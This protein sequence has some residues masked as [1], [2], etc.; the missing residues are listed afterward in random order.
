MDKAAWPPYTTA[1]VGTLLARDC[2]AFEELGLKTEEEWAATPFDDGPTTRKDYLAV[3]MN[4]NLLS[5]QALMPNNLMYPEWE[6]V[7]PPYP[8]HV[9]LPAPHVHSLAPGGVIGCTSR[10]RRRERAARF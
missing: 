7:R 5:L 6:I 10:V 1:G 4:C 3:I 9:H 8:C 2:A